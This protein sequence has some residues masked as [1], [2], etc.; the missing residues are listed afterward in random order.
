[1]R[2]VPCVSSL[3]ICKGPHPLLLAGSR[4]PRGK[5][6]I[7]GIANCLNY[8]EMFVAYTKV[9]NESSG[10]IVQS[11]VMS[12]GHPLCKEWRPTD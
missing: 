7:S 6:A 2:F 9:A 12:F 1:V 8:C 4:A 3:S 5:T 10:L 11:G